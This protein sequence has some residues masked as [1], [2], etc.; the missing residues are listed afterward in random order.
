ML[1]TLRSSME[2]RR[3]KA[4]L[5]IAADSPIIGK[6]IKARIQQPQGGTWQAVLAKKKSK[7]ARA[8]KPIKMP[9]KTP[10]GRRRKSKGMY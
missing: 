4:Q 5:T 10:K 3:R 1:G 8:V 9:K 2:G 7:T 6:E